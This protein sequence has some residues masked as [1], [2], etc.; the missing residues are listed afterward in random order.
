MFYHLG[1]WQGILNV[2]ARGVFFLTL[3]LH[4]PQLCWIASESP[5]HC[6][7]KSPSTSMLSKMPYYVFVSTLT[8]GSQFNSPFQCISIWFFSM[9]SDSTHLN[10]PKPDPDPLPQDF[11]FFSCSFLFFFFNSVII[12]FCF[13]S[14][15]TQ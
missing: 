3:L 11:L 6:L 1:V 8:Q 13:S 14:T 7:F 9:S 12:K 4:F 2:H 10:Y 15:N 5:V